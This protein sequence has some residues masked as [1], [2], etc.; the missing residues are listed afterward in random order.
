[1]HEVAHNGYNGV[2]L[3]LVNRMGAE[4]S[5]RLRPD[6][7]VHPNIVDATKQLATQCP[8]LA[9]WSV[10]DVETVWK[11]MRQSR[12]AGGELGWPEFVAI[13][14]SHARVSEQVG[15]IAVRCNAVC[16]L[17]F[18][19]PLASR[20]NLKLRQWFQL[21]PCC[22]SGLQ[23]KDAVKKTQ[24]ASNY[25]PA[26]I[27]YAMVRD[28]KPAYARLLRASPQGDNVQTGNHSGQF[29]VDLDCDAT[30]IDAQPFAA[31]DFVR[32]AS[33]SHDLPASA[34]SA[35][36]AK[37]APKRDGDSRAPREP[38]HLNAEFVSPVMWGYGSQTHVHVAELSLAEL[39]LDSPTDVDGLTLQRQHEVANAPRYRT[40]ST[41][42]NW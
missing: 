33:V 21:G 40:V 1:M 27:G 23:T 16:M 12:I 41:E 25:H 24:E 2:S 37:A 13:F 17:S 11:R 30:P 36:R 29:R 28:G 42:F 6:K 26:C 4:F 34:A 8:E 14:E 10:A 39:A 5:S 38:L 19:W 18:P 15:S 32:D 31:E 3:L 20:E 9:S 35:E 22:F 7:P